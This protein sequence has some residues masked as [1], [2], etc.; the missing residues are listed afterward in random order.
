MEKIDFEIIKNK[1]L[2]K[3][4][5]QIFDFSGYKNVTS[6][7]KLTDPIYGEWNPTVSNLLSK[8]RE[9]RKRRANENQANKIA[10]ISK[11]IDNI[12]I[13]HND[14]VTI[15]ETTY[16]GSSKK[17]KFFDKDF[18]EFWMTPLHVQNG[19]GHP[20]RA[21]FN[22]VKR[23]ILPLNEVKNRI[24]NVHK[25]LITIEDDSYCGLYKK[26]KFIHILYG[27]WYATPNNIIK[28]ASHPSG[29][30]EKSKNTCMNKYGVDSPQKD[31]SIFLKTTLAR[32]K[33]ITLK[34]WKTKKDLVC[35]SSYEY[36][37][38]KF[39][40]DNKIDFEWQIKFIINN[41][42]VYYID[43][44]MPTTNKFI[45]IKGFF[46]SERNKMKW[47]TF[48]KLYKNSEIWFINEVKKFVNKTEYRIKKEFK[49]EY[50]K[51]KGCMEQPTKP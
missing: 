10:P 16:I 51:I 34:H 30:K 20:K 12:K 31:K 33:Y 21:L 1:L 14:N 43:L 22:Q 4:P 46:F 45:E 9:C 41:D 37:V 18:G 29:W 47:E 50:E 27:E 35:I 32:W 44:Y 15:D 36:A 5:D 39:L 13:I 40:N 8:K 3:Y 6:K 2:Q 49:L 48:H 28:G 17:C 26:A 24:F 38:V 23:T 25:N 7:I 19:S 11:I 42:F